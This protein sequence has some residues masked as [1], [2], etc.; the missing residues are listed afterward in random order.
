MRFTALF[1]G[2]TMTIPQLQS[3]RQETEAA[4]EAA[5]FSVWLRNVAAVEP[6]DVGYDVYGLREEYAGWCRDCDGDVRD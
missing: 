1:R 2:I 6:W 5:D 3:A 4:A